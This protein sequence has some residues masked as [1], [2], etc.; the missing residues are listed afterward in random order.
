[1]GMKPI[2]LDKRMIGYGYFTYSIDII[3]SKKFT[4]SRQWCFETFG[5]SLEIDLWIPCNNISLKNP[6]WAWERGW[7]NKTYRSRI[8]FLTD[9][10][11]NWFTL[12][13]E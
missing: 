13:W 8:F 10:E 5:P 9:K 1:M 12:R 2:K 3:Q 7:S 11:V 6:L 4:E